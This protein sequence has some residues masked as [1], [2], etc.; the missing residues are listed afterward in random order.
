MIQ[1]YKK[2]YKKG[3]LCKSCGVLITDDTITKKCRSC[4]K[5]GQRLSVNHKKRISSGNTR[6]GLCNTAIYN[7]WESMKNRCNNSKNVRFKDYGG[8]GIT[9]CD[10]WLKFKNFYKDM[11]NRPKGKTLDRINN[12]GNY[13]PSNCKWSTPKEQANNRRNTIII[14]FKGE[15]FTVAEWAKLNNIKCNTMYQRIKK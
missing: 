13:K 5:I 1:K 12:D 10:R 3:T 6:H 11:E 9:V 14:K 2:H 4:A 15:K 7:S 8:R